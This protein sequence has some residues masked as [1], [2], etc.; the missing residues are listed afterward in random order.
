MRADDGKMWVPM[1]HIIDQN[2]QQNMW[3]LYHQ[4]SLESSEST[5]KINVL[6]FKFGI[7]RRI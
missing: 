6:N 4:D 1:Y 2:K 5:A 3:V 7:P